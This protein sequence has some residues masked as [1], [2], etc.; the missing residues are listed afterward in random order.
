MR[1]TASILKN[2]KLIER[3][4]EWLMSPTIKVGQKTAYY[5]ALTLAFANQ[6][7]KKT[8]SVKYLGRSF[9][10]DNP[11]TPLNLQNYPHEIG[12]KVLRNM[13]I[14][15]RKV[16]DIGGNIGQFSCTL[17][18]MLDD[19]CVI[20][21][22]EPNPLICAI[23]NDNL[24]RYSSRF[25]TFNFGLGSTNEISKM[26]FEVNR[27]G[28]G[29]LIKENASENQGALEEI[30]IEVTD[31]AW[32]LTKTKKYDLVKIDVEGFENEAIK[33][34]NNIKTKYLFVEVSGSGRVK[35]F[36]H[37]ELFQNIANTL[38]EFDLVYISSY[39]QGL[40]TFDMLLK[41]H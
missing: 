6:L 13:D 34:L 36:N 32:S 38:G 24:S 18:A 2:L 29:S 19:S 10:Y 16:L 33:A 5:P 11:A 3:N 4:K 22:F 25:K 23:L 9:I 21:S 31:D 39:H 37:A 30:P 1:S 20:H 12:V 40:S 14:K 7:F 28:I 8:K 15:P 17:S 35:L 41:F 27:S 26:Y